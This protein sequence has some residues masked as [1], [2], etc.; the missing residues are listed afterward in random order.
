MNLFLENSFLQF[1]LAP[2]HSA[3]SLSGFERESPVLEELRMSAGYRVG[4]RRFSALERWEGPELSGPETV[5]SPHGPLRQLNLHCVPDP[6][7]LHFTLNFALPDQ[8]PIFL[9]KLTVNNRGNQPVLLDRIELLR[10]GALP[11]VSRKEAGQPSSGSRIVFHTPVRPRTLA[12]S[13]AFFSNGWQSWSYTG[14]YTPPNLP[15]HRLG[16]CEADQA[17]PGST[18]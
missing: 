17:G 4:R 6:N 15:A 9:W 11:G 5:A 8:Q 10:A 18:G 7:G 1:S 13:L 14:V 3:W 2:A 12:S 16:R